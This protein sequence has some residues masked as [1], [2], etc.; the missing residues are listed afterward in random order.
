MKKY[1]ILPL[2]GAATGIYTISI[3]SNAM[4]YLLSIEISLKTMMMNNPYFK[5]ILGA[6][7]G[8]FLGWVI[9]YNRR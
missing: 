8:A 2:I 1:I 7:F 9:A 5:I 6:V 3:L 4:D